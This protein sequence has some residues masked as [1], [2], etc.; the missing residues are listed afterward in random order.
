MNFTR[1]VHDGNLLF[2]FCRIQNEFE[3]MLNAVGKVVNARGDFEMT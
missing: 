3:I 2:G 1:K